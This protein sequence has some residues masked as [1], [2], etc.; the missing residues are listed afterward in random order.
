MVLPQALKSLFQSS[1]ARLLGGQKAASGGCHDFTQP[2][3]FLGTSRTGTLV[4]HGPGRILADGLAARLP[5]IGRLRRASSN[6]ERSHFWVSL[7]ARNVRFSEPSRKM[8]HLVALAQERRQRGIP[9]VLG[10]RLA[11]PYDRFWET[12]WTTNRQFLRTLS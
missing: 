7:G 3:D 8:R 12:Q 5:P 9:A 1:C 2:A 4:F 6:P 10:H 11:R